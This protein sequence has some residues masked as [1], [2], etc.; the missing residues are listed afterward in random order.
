MAHAKNMA[1]RLGILEGADV[2][3]NLDA[4]NFTGQ[5]FAGYIGEQMQN[6]QQFMWARKDPGDGRPRGI[7]GRIIV[8][9]AAF[10]AAGG[11]DEKYTT[12][13]PDDKDF[14]ARLERMGEDFTAR[15]PYRIFERRRGPQRPD[16]V[17]GISRS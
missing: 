5:D 6:P 13:S 1:H 7:S 12:W 17:S 11:Y 14:H 16:A 3:V 8:T 9:R 2:L 10:L 15:D 4:D